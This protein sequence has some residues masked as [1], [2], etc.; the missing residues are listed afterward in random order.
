[1]PNESNIESPLIIIGAGR[2]GGLDQPAEGEDR[3]TGG[4]RVDGRR[5]P[6]D[7]AAR[8]ELLDALVRGRPADA[9]LGAQ[10]RIRTPSVRLETGEEPGVDLVDLVGFGAF[11]HNCRYLLGDTA[12]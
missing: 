6:A 4:D 1:M 7:H 5:I 8:F 10:V 9:D 12:C 2:A 11:W 3:E